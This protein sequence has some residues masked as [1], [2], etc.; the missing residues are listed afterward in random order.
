MC[1]RNCTSISQKFRTTLPDFVVQYVPLVFFQFP[2]IFDL[3]IYT[4]FILRNVSLIFSTG[5]LRV[6]HLPGY[7][8]YSA[9]LLLKFE[10]CSRRV[11]L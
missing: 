4:Y 2:V 5:S 3:S 1:S 10:T 7:R 9:Q 11:P 6:L 8:L